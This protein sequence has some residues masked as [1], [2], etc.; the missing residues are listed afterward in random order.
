MEAATFSAD[1][2]T[3]NVGNATISASTD[4][5]S[6]YNDVVEV[7]SKE[8]ARKK[9]KVTAAITE[10]VWSEFEAELW[11]GEK[12]H[13]EKVIAGDAQPRKE[14]NLFDFTSLGLPKQLKVSTPNGISPTWDFYL[15]LDM[16]VVDYIEPKKNKGGGGD[17]IRAHFPSVKVRKPFTHICRLCIDDLKQTSPT[18]VSFKRALRNI[19]NVGNGE[20]HLTTKHSENAKVV[21]YLEE[22]QNKKISKGALDSG[23]VIVEKKNEDGTTT[24][25]TPASRNAVMQALRKGKDETTRDL[26]A[27]WLINNHLGHHTTQSLEFKALMTHLD[28]EFKSIGR[29]TFLKILNEQFTRMVGCIKKLLSDG[30]NYFEGVQW[31]SVGHDI[32]NTVIMDGALGSC[33]RLMTA[34]MEVYNIASV[35]KKHNISHGANDVGEVLEEVYQTRY[36]ISLLKES[37]YVASDTTA[38]ARNVSATLGAVQVRLST[39]LVVHCY[40]V[41]CVLTK[42]RPTRMIVRCI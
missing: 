19:Q 15:C 28:P 39:V 13:R 10:I 12:R 31:L 33:V 21:R 11:E 38:C 26:T 40:L 20:K 17:G 18:I 2:A 25:S 23:Y 29:D 9:T 35:L 36:G 16:K 34:D 4:A 5:A 8:P 3:T 6:S 27:T 22:K 41:T 24:T 30:A 7:S 42:H 14:D 37:G 32:W 1:S